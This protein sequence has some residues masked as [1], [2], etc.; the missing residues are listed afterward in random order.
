MGVDDWLAD[1]VSDYAVYE[2]RG[3]S[4]AERDIKWKEFER[5]VEAMLSHTIEDEEERI[6]E[7]EAL[8]RSSCPARAERVG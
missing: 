7:Q 6:Q 5:R 2:L 3:L 1:I 4:R 8:Q